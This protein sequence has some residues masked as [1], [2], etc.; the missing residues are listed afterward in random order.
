MGG[1]GPP[2][3]RKTTLIRDGRNIPGAVQNADDDDFVFAWKVV[4][5]ILAVKDHA[6]VLRKMGTSGSGEREARGVAESGLNLGDKSACERLG[7]FL[8]QIAPN[9]D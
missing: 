8:G 3:F 6:Q 5:R 7:R 2:S 4:D 9:L 1:Y